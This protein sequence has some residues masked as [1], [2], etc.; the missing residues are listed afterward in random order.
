MSKPDTAAKLL[1]H[2]KAFVEKHNITG[3]EAIYQS[4][5]VQEDFYE[6]VEKCCEIA[7]YKE[8]ED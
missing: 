8:V 7:G 4:D 5:S 1:A 2:V 3:G 6:F